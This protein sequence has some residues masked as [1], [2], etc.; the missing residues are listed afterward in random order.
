MTEGTFV[1][2]YRLRK[3]PPARKL[4]LAAA[5][6]FVVIMRLTDSTPLSLMDWVPMVVPAVAIAYIALRE[7]RGRT[8]VG[9]EGITAQGVVRERRIAWADIHDIRPE[10]SRNTPLWVVW[11][12]DH[13]GRRFL[14]PQV[15]NEQMA[16]PAEVEALLAAWTAGR[17]PEWAQRPGTEA[18][19]R[20]RAA[21]RAAWRRAGNVGA[22]VLVCV[23]VLSIALIFM[24]VWLPAYVIF[25]VPAAVFAITG[26]ALSRRVGK[27]E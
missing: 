1:Q 4:L 23:F 15:N 11:V 16:D 27:V 19:I 13:T 26:A 22:I 3:W 6:L 7:V 20:L 9:P 14:L 10:P 2:E 5:W 21:R 25:T 24:D 12:Y 17:G 8:V 18:A